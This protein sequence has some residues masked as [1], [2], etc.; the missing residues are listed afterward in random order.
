MKYLLNSLSG[1]NA[2]GGGSFARPH[3]IFILNG[4]SSA[5]Y[6]TDIGQKDVQLRS[7]GASVANFTIRENAGSNWNEPAGVVVDPYGNIYVADYQN[8]LVKR[9]CAGLTS[10]S[11]ILNGASSSTPLMDDPYDLAFDNNLNLYVAAKWTHA[12]YKFT[13]V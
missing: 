7:S 2:F 4:S 12:V 5:I 10:C 9:C 13:R 6:V 3:S 8:K 11:T 1:T